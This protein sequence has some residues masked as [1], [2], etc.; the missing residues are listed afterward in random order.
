MDEHPGNP[1]RIFKF[2]NAWMIHDPD[3]SGIIACRKYQPVINIAIT[4]YLLLLCP[5]P[6]FVEFG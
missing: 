5:L 4:P 1:Q 6:G 3:R 2:Y